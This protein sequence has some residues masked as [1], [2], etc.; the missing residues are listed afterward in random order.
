[1]ISK[2]TA[3]IQ[4]RMSSSRLPGKVMLDIGGKPM[5]SQVVERTR[6]AKTIDQVI[7]ATT[8]DPGDDPIEKLCREQGY[9]YYRGSLHDVLDRYYQAARKFEAAFVVRITADCPV[10]DPELIDKTVGAFRGQPGTRKQAAGKQSDMPDAY[11][12]LPYD[13]AANRL[14]P[15]WG[16]T[17][18]IGLD[19]EVC[20]FSALERAWGETDL[21][22]HRE[23]VMPYFYDDIPAAGFQPLSKNPQ[24]SEG[25]SWR[26][27][28]VLLLNYPIDYGAMRWTVDTPE[29]LDLVRQIFA[30]FQNSNDFS[31]LEVLDL[32]ERQPTL[33][34][35]N[36]RV[37]HKTY[38]EIDSRR[39]G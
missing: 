16:R 14:P 32:F 25:K 9:D 3:I 37:Q 12:P 13:F 8:T 29:D 39:D 6:R 30:H 24:L 21:P 19:T 27:F 1:M 2:T 38:R 4:A 33:A 35:I 26:G 17:Y 23:H 34:Q 28:R 5:L 7:V 36:A 31:W 15:P 18:P 10:I 11:H 20:T 22:H